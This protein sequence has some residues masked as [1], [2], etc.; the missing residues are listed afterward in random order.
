MKEDIRDQFVRLVN[1]N[2]GIIFKV[3]NIYAE[4]NKRDDLKQEIIYQLWRSYPSFRGEAKFQT[5]MYRVALNTALYEKS[6]DKRIFTEYKA[7]DHSGSAEPDDSET[8]SNIRQLYSFI[9]RLNPIDKA[10]TF[11]YLEKCSYREIADV[12]GLTEKNIGIR[13]LRIKEKLRILFK[14]E[15]L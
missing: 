6:R 10:I 9:N 4:A 8:E 15:N 14:Q 13:M 2:I 7:D 1:E 3:C 12:M 5:W 11:L